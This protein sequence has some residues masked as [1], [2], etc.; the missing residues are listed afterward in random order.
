MFLTSDFFSTCFSLSPAA[1]I[2]SLSRLYEEPREP[3]EGASLL[4]R[5]IGGRAS[6]SMQG[7]DIF[8]LCVADDLRAKAI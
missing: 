5:H 4:R 6:S 2:C 8:L 3:M 1:S 7:T